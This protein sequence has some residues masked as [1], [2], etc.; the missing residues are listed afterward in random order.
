MMSIF[1]PSGI[2]C[3]VDSSHCHVLA[4]GVV[5]R[6][7]AYDGPAEADSFSHLGNSTSRWEPTYL[8]CSI[9][10]L[11]PESVPP[12]AQLPVTPYVDIVCSI[13]ITSVA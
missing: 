2:F 4:T 10:V 7:Q 9:R 5:T 8:I 11:H 6:S 3:A 13:I 1:I 12:Q